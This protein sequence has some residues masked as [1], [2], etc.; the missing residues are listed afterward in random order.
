MV[1]AKTLALTTLAAVTLGWGAAPAEALTSSTV[2]K[3]YT[4][5]SGYV[6]VDVKLSDMG[7]YGRIRV[8]LWAQP[9]ADITA[10]YFNL[11]D[12]SLV[13][14]LYISDANV[15]ITE[16]KQ[17]AYNVVYVGSTENNMNGG[18]SYNP[19]PYDVGVAIGWPQSENGDYYP[20]VSFVLE[21]YSKSL[22][23]DD[24]YGQ[25]LGARVHAIGSPYG[26]GAKT[27]GV[28]NGDY[29]IPEPVTAGLTMASL[30]ALAF[31]TRRRRSV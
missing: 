22:T 15:P 6:D 25:Y 12:K 31:T 19:G 10:F 9:Y 28:L 7:G 11:A 1:R 17:S 29:A 13:G 18:G 16:I 21:H 26:P 20:Y 30:G 4:P 14:G 3:P 27:K 8:E 2:L 5:S 23:L 24:F